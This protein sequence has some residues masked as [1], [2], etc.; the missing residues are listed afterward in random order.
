MTKQINVGFNGSA[1]S[2]EAVQWA[3][4]EASFAGC[5]AADYVS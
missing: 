2:S 1:S 3:A 4:A 5:P